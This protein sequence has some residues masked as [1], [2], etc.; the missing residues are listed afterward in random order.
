MTDKEILCLDRCRE[1]I[2]LLR[3]LL[4]TDKHPFMKF[5][6]IFFTN[7]NPACEKLNKIE[8]ELDSSFEKLIDSSI[9]E[10]QTIIDEL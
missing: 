6:G 3:S 1:N 4:E 8:R 2:K 9:N 10:L 5:A 7:N